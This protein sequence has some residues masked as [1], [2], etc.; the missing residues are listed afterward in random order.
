[1][2]SFARPNDTFVSFVGKLKTTKIFLTVVNYFVIVPTPSKVYF[3]YSSI[4]NLWRMQN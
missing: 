4:T 1:M 3:V 2:E